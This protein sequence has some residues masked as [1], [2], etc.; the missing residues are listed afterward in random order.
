M[1][2]LMKKKI[3]SQVLALFLI[4][5]ICVPSSLVS[6]QEQGFESNQ[7]NTFTMTEP[8]GLGYPLAT[9]GSTEFIN[10]AYGVEEEDGKQVNVLYTSA[11][12]DSTVGSEA[13]AKFVVYDLDNRKI[14]RDF[15]LPGAKV[16]WTH[17]TDSQGNV[18]I[19]TQ[20]YANVFRYSPV[21]KE[22]ESLGSIRAS[23]GTLQT[24]IY[25]VSFDSEDNA[26][27]GTYPSA[28]V[29]KY[30]VQQNQFEI[31]K[32][33]LFGG[34]YVKAHVIADDGY[35]Y[36]FGS[37][38]TE[39][40]FARLDLDSGA[41]T[42]LPEFSYTG[43]FRNHDGI[44]N[45]TNEKIAFDKV[46]GL[47]LRGNYLF[48]FVE[49]STPTKLA[50]LVIF[51]I[52]NNRWL[53]EPENVIRNN[54]THVPPALD[55]KV[56]VW[57][58][59]YL[60]LKYFDLTTGA[61]TE[62][63]GFKDGDVNPGMRGSTFIEFDD[64]EELPGQTLVTVQKNG[65]VTYNS[66]GHPDGSGGFTGGRKFVWANGN[67]Y[68][69]ENITVEAGLQPKVIRAL[70]TGPAGTDTI[71]IGAYMGP[72]LGILNHQTDEIKY[73]PMEQ[74]EGMGEA[75]GK[76]YASVYPKA[77]IFTVDF[78]AADFSQSTKTFVT[79]LSDDGLEQDRPF[80]L[81]EAGD[82]VAISSVPDYG[83][84]NGALTLLPKAD[85]TQKE[86]YKG[87]IPNQSIIGLAYK[88]G[89]IYGS[90]S[91]WGGLGIDPVDVN[92]KLF[93]F[94]LATKTVTKV[95]EPDLD[96]VSTPVMH[97]GGLSIGPNGDLWAISNGI[98]FEVDPDTLEVIREFKTRDT[99]WSAN[100]P[101][102]L[103][104]QISWLSDTLM[105]T[106]PGEVLSVIDTQTGEMRK[107]TNKQAHLMA[108]SE[109]K[110][111]IYFSSDHQYKLYKMDISFEA[112]SAPGE[113]TLSAADQTVRKGAEFTV[114]VKIEKA[115]G[116]VGLEGVLNYD[117]GLIELESF[118]FTEFGEN[119]AT[120]DD[121]AGKISFAGVSGDRIDT[122]EPVIVANV[123][124]RAKADISA[125]ET[126][127]ISFSSVRGVIEGALGEAQYASV[128]TKN[129][130]I[131]ITSRVPGDV[132]GD[133]V[134]DLLDARAILKLIVSGE[135]LTGSDAA[136]VNGDG[137]V[138][139]SDVLA[140]LQIIADRLASST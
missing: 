11:S 52:A 112:N 82:Y 64:Q 9:S 111:S 50:M 74:V 125:D 3:F 33:N 14:L 95:V 68:G 137:A 101:W 122:D 5:A 37:T 35:M 130:V 108:V 134:I 25:H 63:A 44:K 78:N 86:V 46:Q 60:K 19:A 47:T 34:K 103:P 93:I 65:V 20:S 98:I 57:D 54:G 99:S 109:D 85:N 59:G 129:A 61:Y 42:E 73:I 23:D 100:N 118:D 21:T 75:H 18:Y 53:T 49:A 97:I 124:F 69:Y 41:I 7:L 91:V 117:A 38:E 28:L 62:V 127:T 107:L 88:D 51:D 45:V 17:G 135:G 16:I 106:N 24:A 87:I 105:V 67:T 133:N 90:T 39:A 136:D 55:N 126:T 26:Y 70:E 76:Y 114:P 22:L 27:F 113:I 6:A 10:S 8:E 13:P 84:L 56:Y 2:R 115:R 132:N 1:K 29:V 43:P 123:K 12:G 140:L 120:N 110:Q 94:D 77:E 66:F 116:F 4:V 121:T 72:V 138:D 131:T 15:P 30:D 128:L 139:T 104:Y 89:K 80:E 32:E 102:Y 40:R 58:R 92:A 79:K 119:G 71:I 36:L 96:N 83:V 81:I 48:A 31:I